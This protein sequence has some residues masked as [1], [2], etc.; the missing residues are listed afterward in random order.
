MPSRQIMA[1]FMLA[2][3]FSGCAKQLPVADPIK[4]ALQSKF[5]P[6]NVQI[7][8]TLGDKNHLGRCGLAR[9]STG[10]PQRPVKDTLFIMDRGRVYTP[11]DPSPDEF[12]SLG[13][14][15]CGPDWVAPLYPQ[16]VS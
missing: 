12:A 6:S 13:K 8:W 11:Y 5:G 15:I 10:I 9:I 4:Q 7:I 16:A 2:T 14:K 3:C 1:I